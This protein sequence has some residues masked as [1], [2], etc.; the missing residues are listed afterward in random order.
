[1][2]KVKKDD[3]MKIVENEVESPIISEP[4]ELKASLYKY[5]IGDEVFTMENN[6]VH[7]FIVGKRIILSRMSE[8]GI[9]TEVYYDDN[10]WGSLKAQYTEESLFPSK[11]ELLNSL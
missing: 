6:R 9:I 4:I 7:S 8:D 5:E 11:K 3:T 10:N 2:A 1:M